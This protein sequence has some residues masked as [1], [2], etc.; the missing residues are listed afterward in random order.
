MAA[1]ALLLSFNRKGQARPLHSNDL[2]GWYEDE[3]KDY[4]LIELAAK[5][6][7]DA[8]DLGKPSATEKAHAALLEKAGNNNFREGTVKQLGAAYRATDDNVEGLTVCREQDLDSHGSIHA[9][10]NG[11]VDLKDHRDVLLPPEEARQY[12]CTRIISTEYHPDARTDLVD[13]FLAN[14]GER[15][16]AFILA[17][18]GF[19]MH[20]RPGRRFPVFWGATASGKTTLFKVLLCTMPEISSTLQPAALA[21]KS[22]N[23]SGLSPQFMA[24]IRGSAFATVDEVMANLADS[25]AVKEITGGGNIALR[26]LYEKQ[27]ATAALTATLFSA[28]NAPPQLDFLDDAMLARLT[29]IELPSLPEDR[30]IEDVA[31]QIEA[32]DEHKQAFVARI[33]RAARDNPTMPAKPDWMQAE[34]EAVQREALVDAARWLMDNIERTGRGVDFVASGGLWEKLCRDLEVR[35]WMNDKA[36]TPDGIN[37]SRFWALLKKMHGVA[38]VRTTS[39]GKQHRGYP[40]LKWREQGG[41]Q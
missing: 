10:A 14:F 21:G 20:R 25:T 33:V 38:P 9:F 40:G 31:E 23:S 34:I 29:P 30:I 39:N 12:L 37:R 15:N 36:E 26:G 19:A 8:I 22:A 24:M 11:V 32:S 3:S 5:L 28:S 7:A 27:V 35:D 16:L 4:A 41:Q 17:T 18:L 13:T 6:K 2:G 1:P